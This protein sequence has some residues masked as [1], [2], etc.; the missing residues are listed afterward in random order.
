M[1]IKLIDTDGAMTQCFVGQLLCGGG[2]GGGLAWSQQES[3]PSTLGSE[4][5]IVLA[6]ARPSNIESELV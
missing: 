6:P 1:C 5:V 3:V 4:G 2:G